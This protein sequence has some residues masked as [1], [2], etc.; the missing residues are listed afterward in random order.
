MRAFLVRALRT[1]A[2]E[3]QELEAIFRIPILFEPSVHT[4]AASSNCSAVSTTVS[5]NMVNGQK[6]WCIFSAT[7][8]PISI[9]S[10]RLRSKFVVM[11]FGVLPSISQDDYLSKFGFVLFNSRPTNF[12][13][14]LKV[15]LCL[16]ANHFTILKVVSLVVFRVRFFI[17]Q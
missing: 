4:R 3:T 16:R 13:V 11:N 1:I 7:L 10:K 2:I 8:T 9:R 6:L 15:F 5:V 14:L 12:L 17:Y